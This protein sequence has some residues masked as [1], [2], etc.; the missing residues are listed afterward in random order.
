MIFPRSEKEIRTWAD[1]LGFTTVHRDGMYL[2][3]SR[4]TTPHSLVLESKTLAG[5][6][7]WLE[8]WMRWRAA[9]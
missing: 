8:K 4:Y 2:L 1:H 7:R 6:I 3:Y 9:G 5:V